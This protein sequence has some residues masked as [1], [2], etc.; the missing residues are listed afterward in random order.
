[1]LF[2][3]HFMVVIKFIFINKAFY[4]QIENNAVGAI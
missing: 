1:M 2:E 4:Q 3:K